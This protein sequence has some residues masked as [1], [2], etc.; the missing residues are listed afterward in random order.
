MR[1]FIGLLV[2]LILGCPLDAKPKRIPA[3][4]EIEPWQQVG[5][6]PYE[7]TWVQR[8]E[9]L[10]T[11]V[12]FEDLQGWTLELG[13]GAKGELRRSREQ[14]MWG[15]YVAKITYSGSKDQ[16]RVVARPPRPVPVPGRFDC[17][18]MWG[19]GNR[20]S[21][22]EDPTTPPAEVS[23]LLT[24]AKGK[25]FRVQ[26]TSIQWKQWWLI[27]RKIPVS[28]LREMATPVN[29]SGIEI[30]KARN[31]QPRYFFCDSLAFFTEELKPLDFQPQ[32]QRNL[33][34]YGG[35]IAGVNT[36]LST[37]TF[38]TREETILPTNFEKDFKTGVKEAGH[39]L[40]ELTYRGPDA[41]VTYEYRPTEG[42]LDEITA[43]VNEHPPIHPLDSG[44]L[45][46]TDTPKEQT[47][48][49][50]LLAARITD[51]AIEADFGF[52]S[53]TAH[54][55]LRL[56]GKS[57]VLDV[58]CPGGEAVELDFGHLSGVGQARLITVP[59]LTYG[60]S[61]P[62]VLLWGDPSQPLFAS[63]WFDW[64]RS[65]ASEP[66]FGEPM[67]KSDSA[68]INGGM[69][70]NPKTDGRRNDLYERIFLTVSPRYEETL[71]TTANPSSLRKEEGKQVLWTVTEPETFQ[72]DHRRCQMIRS[73]GLDK[74]MQHSHEVTWRDEGDSNTMKLQASPQKGGDAMLKWYIQVQNDLGWLQGVYSNYT[75]FCTVNTNWNP[76]FV[77]RESDGEWRRA[78]PRNYA[79]KPVKAV[80]FDEYYAKRIKEKFGVKMSYTDVHSAVAPW[81]YCDY[82][83]RVPGAGTLAATFYAYGQLLL[84]DQ[85]VYGPTQ[86]E[87]TYQWLYAGLASGH[88]GWVYTKV[89]LLTHPLDVAFMLMKLHPLEC[90]Y[91]MG[92]TDYYLSQLDPNWAKSPKRREYVDLFLATTIGYGNMGWLVSEFDPATPFGME[93]MV[94]S[95]YMM[96][97][98]QQQYAFI[99]PRVIEYADRTGRFYS[100]SQAH[101]TGVIADSR[102]HVLYEN[103]AEVY[104]NR[105]DSLPWVVPDKDE[106]PIE[107]PVSGWMAVNPSAGFYE[108]SANLEGRRID[109]VS[110]SDYEFLD[111]RGKW[112]EHGNLGAAGSV[113]M[114]RKPGGVLELIDLIGNDRIAFSTPGSGVL[115]SYNPE[116]RELGRVE[117]NPFRGGW[118]VFR[119]GT[120][121]RRYVYTPGQP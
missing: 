55:Q 39:S 101:A 40:F 99:P 116:D 76:D 81:D 107:L 93:A 53:R 18:E 28:V 19:Y 95:Y 43:Q 120:G 36:G 75:D 80:E 14:Q 103:G 118:Y 42:T 47:A 41:A 89:N 57:L 2:F 9:D 12:D 34:P 46:F 64:Y 52:G 32:P 102:L 110:S 70:Y 16:S 8:Q 20:W 13:E 15:Q 22:V 112:T 4:N 121:A 119:P 49:G 94:R 72:K 1:Q 109:Y 56:W 111:G 108:I 113:V 31:H 11:L 45:R 58:R 61:N 82:D 114:R 78:W 24:D 91:G 104:V 86:S 77:Q 63:I 10:R 30:S 37:L 97:Q 17:M 48:R 106:R 83:A 60:I 90:D 6:Q 27:H 87:A 85:R 29:F 73:F 115:V 50:Q 44:G 33:R 105:A 62:R 5:Q 79:L 3:I 38:P 7:M 98:L 84:N 54:Y 117:L 69:R 59:Y 25:E 96:Q 23:V 68:R 67:L 21:W 74:L 88:Y 100:P 66:Y 51:G 26:L 35:Q 65:N 92:Y 71:P